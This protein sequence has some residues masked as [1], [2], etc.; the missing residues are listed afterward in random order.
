M[1]GCLAIPC[2]PISFQAPASASLCEGDSIEIEISNISTPSFAVLWNGVPISSNTLLLSPQQDTSLNISLIDSTQLLCAAFSQTV[3]IDIDDVPMMSL[4]FVSNDSLCEGDLLEVVASPSGLDN[5]TFLNGFVRE[6]NSGNPV[7]SSSNWTNGDSLFVVGTNKGCESEPSLALFPNVQEELDVPNVN[8]GASTLSSV[9]FFWDTIA[10]ASSYQVR[11]NQA[12]FSNPSSGPNGTTHALTGLNPGDRVLIEVFAQSLGICGD[13]AIS[14]TLSCV[15]QPCNFIDFDLSAD[16]TVCEGDSV[17]IEVD[18][19]Q[20]TNAGLSF[21]GQNF[22]ND[23][24]LAFVADS[25]TTFQVELIDSSQLVCPSV[26]KVFN[27]NVIQPSQPIL[28]SNTDSIC[29]G[30]QVTITTTPRGLDGYEF[31]V[32]ALLAQN[33]PNH[34]LTIN[35]LES[36]DSVYVISR[37]GNCFSERSLPLSIFVDEPISAPQVNCLSSTDT[38]VSFSW[39]SISGAT[40]YLVSV[41]GGAFQTPSS[42]LLGVIHTI[43]GLAQGTSVNLSVQALGDGIC[44]NSALSAVQSC[45]SIQCDPISFNLSVPTDL[46]QGDEV[47]LP[48]VANGTPFPQFSLNGNVVNNPIVSF[49]VQ[50]DTSFTVSLS[51][52]NQLTVLLKSNLLVFQLQKLLY[53]R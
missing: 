41:N 9:S 33:S 30:D 51:D 42:G 23:S 31:Y 24:L 11:I 22:S 18:N 53:F 44:G 52:L 35:S 1:Q 26:S 37:E 34:E 28:T 48:L 43:N 40:D 29:E 36:T 10:N 3:Q 14:D 45:Q 2:T 20:A 12:G 16:A 13:G 27:L 32:D 38:S 49:F 50:E 5:Y 8:C 39:G 25:S 21:I 6:Q 17:I 47:E 15:A 19:I 46:C 4:A 7:F